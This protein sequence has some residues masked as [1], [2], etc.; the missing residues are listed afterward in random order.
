MCE[1]GR[2]CPFVATIHHGCQPSDRDT[3]LAE[4]CYWDGRQCHEPLLRV[5]LG[6]LVLGIDTASPFTVLTADMCGI[7]VDGTL[8][9]VV[10]QHCSPLGR[11]RCREA[12]QCRWRHSTCSPAME[13]LQ[14]VSGKVPVVPWRVPSAAMLHDDLVPY[15][16]AR[17]FPQNEDG[18]IGMLP[19]P[20]G[21]AQE[22][23][24]LMHHILEDDPKERM[25]VVDKARNTVCVGRHCRVTDDGVEERPKLPPG[26]P[27]VAHDENHRLLL[28]TGTTAT[29]V[30]PEMCQIGNLDLEYLEVHADKVRYK[31]A[32][33]ALDRCNSTSSLL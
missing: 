19:A 2:S 18:L 13:K 17:L 33:G 22:D 32:P 21:H 6:D 3:C 23:Q 30:W 7:H 28:D 5:E 1:R 31:L 15:C 24:V 10:Q 25:V 9:D 29:T 12:V 26:G 20:E 8:H 14:Y 27:L 16:S 11:A 4:N